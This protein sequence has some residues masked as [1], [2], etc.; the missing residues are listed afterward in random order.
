MVLKRSLKVLDLLKPA[1]TLVEYQ[2]CPFLF[3]F[4][5]TEFLLKTSASK[6]LERY[7]CENLITYLLK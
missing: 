4:L 3:I 5:D 6:E 2:K 1:G 7:L